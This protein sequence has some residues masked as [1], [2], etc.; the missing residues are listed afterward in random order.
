M[1]M[2]RQCGPLHLLLPIALILLL[3]PCAIGRAADHSPPGIPHAIL[4]YPGFGDDGQTHT[5]LVGLATELNPGAQAILLVTRDSVRI[6]G[7]PGSYAIR[8]QQEAE[9]F[10][11]DLEKQGIQNLIINIDMDIGWSSFISG[12]GDREIDWA[13]GQG[14]MWLSAYKSVHPS[15]IVGSLSHSFGNGAA[16]GPI[17][18]TGRIDYAVMASPGAQRDTLN[19]I[20]RSIPGKRLLVLTAKGDF[21]GRTEWDGPTDFQFVVLPKLKLDKNQAFHTVMVDS[22]VLKDP[23][24]K[25]ATNISRRDRFSTIQELLTTFVD[26]RVRAVKDM[27]PT[28]PPYG[29]GTVTKKRD[30]KNYLGGGPPPPPPPGGGGA[31]DGLG[32]SSGG[33]TPPFPPSRGGGGVAGVSADPHP[34]SA[35]KGGA[36]FKEPILGSDPS[37]Q[38]LYRDFQIPAEKK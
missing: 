23:S 11:K 16:K 8:S 27:R 37:G 17:L 2:T 24:V 14:Q 30:D 22:K 4:V 7:S 25:Y 36:E 20:A 26:E 12:K 32:K 9:S 29:R 19:E 3:R 18:R 5:N 21:H 38:S 35:G 31:A 6:N 1:R 15:G 28:E 34:S 13:S 33:P 10:L